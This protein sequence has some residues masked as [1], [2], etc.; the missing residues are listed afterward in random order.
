MTAEGMRWVRVE[1]PRLENLAEGTLIR[2]M[3]KKK[4]ICFVRVNGSLRALLDVC[5][6]QGNSFI[7]GWCEDGHIVCPHHR[8]KFDPV[9]GRNA[10]DATGKAEVFAVEE[11]S[12]GVYIRLQR[13]RL[14]LLGI[15]LW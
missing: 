1:D 9:T 3:V 10:N 6:H 15:D 7:G 13:P 4:A 14:R 11:R 2:A 12:D 5:P 8:M